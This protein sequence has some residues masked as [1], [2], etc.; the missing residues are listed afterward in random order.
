MSS[1]AIVTFNDPR[2]F[3]SMKLV[4][5]GKLDDEPLLRALGPEPLGNAF[6]AAMLARGLRGQ[7]DEPQG[8]AAGSERRGRARQHL[9]LRGAA[10]A[11]GCR[12]SAGPRPSRREP[13]RRTSAPSG[14]STRIS[15]CSTTPSRPAARRC[16]I[17]AAPTASSA[18]SST[19]SASTTAKAKPCPTPRLRRHHQAHRAERAL[20]VLLPGV[21]EVTACV[22]NRTFPD[23]VACRSAAACYPRSSE[24]SSLRDPDLRHHARDAAPRPG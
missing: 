10:I 21:S 6:D 2:R 9:C 12:R 18:C 4:P 19:I 23:A 13:A 15:A 24:A 17:T 20:D 22:P 5:R 8:G 11:R 3:G 16:A 1:G 14:W 7:E